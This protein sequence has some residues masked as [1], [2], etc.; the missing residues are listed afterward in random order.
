MT[1]ILEGT[2]AEIAELLTQ[3]FFGQ[4]LRVYVDDDAAVASVPTPPGTIQDQ[5]HLE[6]LLL[7]GYKGQTHSVT[8][9]IW[10]QLHA[11]IESRTARKQP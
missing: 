8:D 7:Q 9:D 5:A 4:K 11:R 1:R 2:G 3:S 6:E 10:D